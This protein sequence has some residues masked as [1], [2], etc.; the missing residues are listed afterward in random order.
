MAHSKV[1]GVL[2]AQ[3]KLEVALAEF[4]Q[5]LAISRRL[6]ELD[7]SNAVWQRDLELAYS[8]LAHANSTWAVIK[9]FFLKIRFA[10][11]KLRIWLN[12]TSRKKTRQD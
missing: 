3:G 10:V 7:P 12:T 9:N 1:G 6:A 2:Q 8:R 11:R 4:K 5:R